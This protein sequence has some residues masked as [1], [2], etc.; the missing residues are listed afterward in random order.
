MSASYE[1]N[2]LI[3]RKFDYFANVH[4]QFA[5]NCYTVGVLRFLIFLNLVLKVRKS[6]E[7]RVKK[8]IPRENSR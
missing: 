6:V 5:H 1:L 4:Y 2:D 7:T 8:K 3:L